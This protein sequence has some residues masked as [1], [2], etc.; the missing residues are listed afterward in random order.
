MGMT[1]EDYWYGDASLPRYY[2]KAYELKKQQKNHELWLQGV[3]I[4]DALCC[5]APLF[6]SLDK[7]P[8]PIPYVKHPYDLDEKSRNKRKKIEEEEKAK[9][10]KVS[11]IAWMEKFNQKKRGKD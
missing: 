1:Y 6:R 3:Y 7:H 10:N 2:R 5:A 4:Y 11:F 9:Q 8:K